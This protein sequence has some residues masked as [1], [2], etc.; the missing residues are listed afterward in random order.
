M[1]QQKFRQVIGGIAAACA[2][3]HA[4]LDRELCAI[5]VAGDRQRLYDVMALLISRIGDGAEKE[6][7]ADALIGCRPDDEALYLALANRLAYAGMGVLERDPAIPRQGIAILGR[8]LELAAPSPLR[9]QIHANLSFL[10]NE[11]GRPDLAE[12]HGRAAAGCKNAIFHLWL[13]EALFRQ[14]KYAGDGLCVVDLS[15]LSFRRA[16]QTLARADAAPPFP[17]PFAPDRRHVVLVSVDG[18]YFKRYAAAQILNL[19][20]LGSAVAVHYH[21]INGDP[22]VARLIERLRGIVGAMPVTFSHESWA[23]RGEAIDKPYY[24]SS[25]FLIAAEVMLLHKADVIVC[26][27][28]VLFREKPE[29]IVRLAGDAD[30]AHTDYRGEPLCSRYNASFVYFRHSRSGYLTLLMMADFLRTNFDRCYIWM[31][32]QVALFACVERAAQLL[33]S[34]MAH[35]AWPDSVLPPRAGDTLPLVLTGALAGKHGNSPYSAKRDEILRT[36]GL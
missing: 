13:G 5:E 15:S 8:A 26:D 2:L 9:P 21:I 23:L 4:A 12:V 28:D 32:D 17:P 20:V 7:L 36:Y 27:A 24:A 16:A 3:D 6:R 10:F 19:H 22:E 25:R 34:E 1:D 14:G 11:A 29:E 30:V 33:G 18:T 35:A 31:I